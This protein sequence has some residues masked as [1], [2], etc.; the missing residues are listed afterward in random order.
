M[1][2]TPLSSICAGVF[3]S[4]RLGA[5]ALVLLLLTTTV[6]ASPT[7]SIVGS[8]KDST[9]AAVSGARLTLTNLATNAKIEEV[10]DANGGFQF[11]QL[12]PTEYSL[13]VEARGFKKVS[14]N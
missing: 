6:S 2:R 12:A 11:L 7:G 10:S 4:P 13:A 8:L 3:C 14:E 5:Y 1:R 9:G